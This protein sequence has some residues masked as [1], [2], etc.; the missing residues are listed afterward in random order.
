MRGTWEVLPRLTLSTVNQENG[1]LSDNNPP[2]L[3]DN[4][5][6]LSDKAGLLSGKGEMPLNVFGGS[7]GSLGSF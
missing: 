5:G 6:L 4:P 3:P 2:L 1:T 7:L